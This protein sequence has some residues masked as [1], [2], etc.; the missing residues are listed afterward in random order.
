MSGEPIRRS[1][2]GGAITTMSKRV[3]EAKTKGLTTSVDE[4]G[5]FSDNATFGSELAGMFS[6]ADVSLGTELGVT[7]LGTCHVKGDVG[8]RK[9]ADF[10][11]FF[12]GQ[13]LL[14]HSWS[15]AVSKEIKGKEKSR[16]LP[17]GCIPIMA[18]PIPVGVIEPS[19]FGTLKVDVSG[20]ISLNSEEQIGINLCIHARRKNGE[21]YEYPDCFAQPLV[22]GSAMLTASM[23]ATAK[24]SFGLRLEIRVAGLIGP[25]LTCGPFVE[26]SSTYSGNIGGQSGMTSQCRV[27]GGI[28]GSVGLHAALIGDKALATGRSYAV[29]YENTKTVNPPQ[30]LDFPANQTVDV[31]QQVV[32]AP[33]IYGAEPITYAWLKDGINIGKTGKDLIFTAS[34]QE[35]SGTYTCVAKNDIGMASADVVLT[36]N[37]PQSVSD[38]AGT[39]RQLVSSGRREY[40]EFH[41]NRSGRGYFQSI[42]GGVPI[43]S[44]SAYPIECSFYPNGDL[45]IERYNSGYANTIYRLSTIA[46]GVGILSKPLYPNQS[47]GESSYCRRISR[48]P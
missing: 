3:A 8:L 38:F 20:A 6:I 18:G 45:K 19:L 35:M 5:T 42:Q 24:F 2:N 30:F 4:Q 34:S 41:I 29:L 43:H 16:K 1:A 10:E 40:R 9:S 23:S 28:E 25:Y 44:T 14:S 26:G 37:P 27:I 47:M 12:Q 31:A 11:V 46:D 17:I 7:T 48:T 32:F 39:W 13:V 21:W 33:L 22:D 36:V 15:V